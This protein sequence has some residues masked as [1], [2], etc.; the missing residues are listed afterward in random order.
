MCAVG[1]T[2]PSDSATTKILPQLLAAY[3]WE[4]IGVLHANDEYANAYAEGMRTNAPSYGVYVEA[5]VS[6]EMNGE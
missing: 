2:Y 6:Y 5:S 3:G 4:K 1:R